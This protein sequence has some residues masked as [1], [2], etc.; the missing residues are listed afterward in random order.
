MIKIKN[1]LCHINVEENAHTKKKNIC[2]WNEKK[3]GCGKQLKLLDKSLINS[4]NVHMIGYFFFVIENWY[5]NNNHNLS[6]TNN[7]KWIV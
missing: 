3:E 7:L 6:L 2:W 1:H 4:I 5:I